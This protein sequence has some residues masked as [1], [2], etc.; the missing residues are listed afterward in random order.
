MD[1]SRA[2]QLKSGDETP[3][4]AADCSGKEMIEGSSASL[5]FQFSYLSKL[6][7]GFIQSAERDRSRH[8]QIEQLGKQLIAHFASAL[9]LC[10]QFVR[11]Q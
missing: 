8:D 9:L 6:P 4:L 1:S 5:Q 11:C 7:V 10:E 2:V 3:L